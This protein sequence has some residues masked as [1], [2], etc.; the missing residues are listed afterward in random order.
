MTPAFP[1]LA[2]VR[3]A[4]LNREPIHLTIDEVAQLDE[5]IDQLCAVEHAVTA[6]EGAWVAGEGRL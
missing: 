5:E 4:A 6:R 3:H 2:E 1:L